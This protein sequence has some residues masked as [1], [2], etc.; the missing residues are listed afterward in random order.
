M[1]DQE[2][3]WDLF[4]YM[5]TDTLYLSCF[6]LK[7]E[8]VRL[9]RNLMPAWTQKGTDIHVLPENVVKGLNDEAIQMWGRHVD[10]SELDNYTRI[11]NQVTYALCISWE[12]AQVCAMNV[13]KYTPT[14][15][16]IKFEVMDVFESLVASTCVKS[17]I[18]G[19][20]I[21]TNVTPEL[22]TI[23]NHKGKHIAPIVEYQDVQEFERLRESLLTN[24]GHSVIELANELQLQDEQLV[25]LPVRFHHVLK[26]ECAQ[27]WRMLTKEQGGDWSRTKRNE[28]VRALAITW[29]T[30]QLLTDSMIGRT[31]EVSILDEQAGQMIRGI[32]FSPNEIIYSMCIRMCELAIKELAERNIVRW[33]QPTDKDEPMTRKQWEP[34]RLMICRGRSKKASDSGCVLPRLSHELFAIIMRLLVILPKADTQPQNDADN[35][36]I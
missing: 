31:P 16:P 2:Q 21:A 4:N 20:I 3:R 1:A 17:A 22:S 15:E 11:V 32:Q 14:N 18:D 5:Q 8:Y 7:D 13:A 19:A 25:N 27:W 34:W 23:L 26:I 36:N 12:A 24:V 28:L 35:E 9:V 30:T 6:M 10:H 33:V 29:E